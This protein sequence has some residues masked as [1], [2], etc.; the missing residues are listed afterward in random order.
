LPRNSLPL[1]KEDT[2]NLLLRVYSNLG[3]PPSANP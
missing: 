3:L 1:L 2:A